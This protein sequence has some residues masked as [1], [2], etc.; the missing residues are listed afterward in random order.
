M[1]WLPLA[2]GVVEIVK[3]V[4]IDWPIN[5]WVLRLCFLQGQFIWCVILGQD[6]C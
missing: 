6:C 5:P 1:N 3:G 2:V 4:V